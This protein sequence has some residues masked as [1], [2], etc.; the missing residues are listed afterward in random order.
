[1]AISRAEYSILRDL[2]I[3][4]AVSEKPRL[5][6][7]GDANWYGDVPVQ[8]LADDIR[9]VVEPQRREQVMARLVETLRHQDKYMLFEIAKICYEAFVGYVSRTAV[10][11]NGSPGA[12]R[13]DLNLPIRL[14]GQ[15]DIVVNS[16][17]GEH[18][19]DVR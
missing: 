18:V 14:D 19:F 16:G 13:F 2:C 4:R 7:L 6:E 11:L 17:A 12:L 3:A 10:D 8:Q 1:M 9:R 15:F 5:L